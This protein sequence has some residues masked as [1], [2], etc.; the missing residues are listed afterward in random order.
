MT[1]SLYQSSIPVFLKQLGAMS[2][3][4]KKAEAHAEKKKIDPSVFTTARL[5]P[6]MLPLTRQI[7]IATDAVKGFTARAAGIEVPSFPDTEVTFADLQARIKKA[8]DFAKSVKPAQIDGNEDKDVTLKFGPNEHTFKVQH[9]L[10][11][12]A[13]P[14]FFFHIT[15]AYDILRHNGVEIGKMDFLGESTK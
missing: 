13:L 2:E 10:L 12:F 15:T 14:N 9:Y 4:L 7:Q 8:T 6:D 1:I 5:F 11:H 3:I